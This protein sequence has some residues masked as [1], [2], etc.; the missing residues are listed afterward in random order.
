MLSGNRNFEGRIH[1]NVRS[2]YLASPPLV[3]A[4]ALA[5]NI[6]LDLTKDPIGQDSKG[7][8]V[9]LKDIWPTNEQVAEYVGKFVTAQQFAKSYA[10]VFRGEKQ[11]QDIQVPTGD[12]YKWDKN[13]TYIKEPPFFD[14][15]SAQP[16][17]LNDIKAARVLAL[18]GDSVTTDHI[19]PAGNIGKSSPAGHYLVEHGVKPADFN[20]Y[21]ARRG[22]HEVMVR[23]TFANV[24]LKNLL[25][26]GIEGGVTRHLPDGKQM[27]IFDA[28][29]AVPG[30]RSPSHRDR[31]QRIRHG[32]L[33]RLGGQ[34]AL[35]PG[36]PRGHRREL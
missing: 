32:L 8:S 17:A 10:D 20:S 18:L 36:H 5:G 4:Y 34:G 27:S 23:G 7:Q 21:G 28:S 30:R 31:G 9:Y 29:H 12:L 11:W 19:S 24:R 1:P 14:G 6:N 26:K 3:V 25:C 22:N 35:A 16:K 33:A 15:I 2:N 13:S